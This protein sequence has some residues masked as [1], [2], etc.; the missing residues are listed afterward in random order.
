[1][2][3]VIE[4]ALL[5]AMI[6]VFTSLAMAAHYWTDSL[7]TTFTLYGAPCVAGFCCGRVTAI[8]ARASR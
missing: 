3:P 2:N 8:V 6:T 1:M 5:L 4:T 7:A